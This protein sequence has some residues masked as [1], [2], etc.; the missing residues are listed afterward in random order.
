MPLF[1][2]I[3]AHYNSQNLLQRTLDSIRNSHDTQVIVIDDQSSEPSIFRIAKSYKNKHVTFIYSERKITAGG[4]RNLGLKHAKGKYVIFADSDDF[5]SC[6]AFDKFNKVITSNSDLYQFTVTSFIEGTSL[7]GGRHNY[8]KPIYND[9]GLARFL[10]IE[11]PVAKLIKHSLI[12]KHNVKFSEVPAG[13]D[14]LFSARIALYSKKRQFVNEVVYN[15]SQNDD[16]ITSNKSEVNWSSRI[17][18]QIKKTEL[19][20]HSTHFFFWITFLPR[21]NILRIT[22]EHIK[23]QKHPSNALYELSKEYN[24]TMPLSVRIVFHVVQ[25][26]K[27]ICTKMIIFFRS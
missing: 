26:V 14:I 25:S 24:S 17:K 5:F 8:L 22:N 21:R 9:F 3:I 7:I 2:V 12:K 6:G 10:A 11:Q 20:T 23:N 15:I 27:K 19:I 1:S 16:S 18:E 4:A 13:N